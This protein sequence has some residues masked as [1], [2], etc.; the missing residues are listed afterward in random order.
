M[1]TMEDDEAIIS[2]YCEKCG[3]N[4]TIV[5]LNEDEQLGMLGKVNPFC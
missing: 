3:L 5:D 2:F 4:I 1:A